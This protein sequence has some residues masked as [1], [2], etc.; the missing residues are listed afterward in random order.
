MLEHQ[1]LAGRWIDFKINY[2]R[3]AADGKLGDDG[4]TGIT[5][6]D[7][8]PDSPRTVIAEDVA[9]S[10]RSVG[11]AAVKY[12]AGHG[13]VAVA[14]I[15]SVLRGLVLGGSDGVCDVRAAFIALPIGPAG[16]VAFVHDR[17]F[18]PA[19]HPD[20][21]DPNLAGWRVDFKFERIAETGS[22]DL[23]AD[24]GDVRCGDRSA[25]VN[26]GGPDIGVICRYLETGYAIVGGDRVVGVRLEV[27]R[28]SV[29]IDA[30][31]GGVL[32]L[33]DVLGVAVRF[34]LGALVPEGNVKVS[35]G[36]KL[37]VVDAVVGVFL[38]DVEEAQLGGKDGGLGGG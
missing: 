5:G 27:F 17:D 35:I 13:L 32:V 33:G 7:Q 12:A 14:V 31:D 34:A 21:S 19:A 1:D 15:V 9:V 11:G 23:G 4:G 25:V 24:L 29:D 26:R 8:A 16:V 2:S 10:E 6:S 37:A 30:D 22:P 20:I 18:L 38:G 28:V 36:A 3:N